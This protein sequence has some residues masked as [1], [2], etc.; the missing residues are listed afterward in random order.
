MK[1]QGHGHAG[2]A[3]SPITPSN[4]RT[5]CSSCTTSA[6]HASRSTA[7]FNPVFEM[8]CDPYIEAQ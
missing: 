7:I 1:S 4:I 3:S 2:V 6:V 5:P 8:L